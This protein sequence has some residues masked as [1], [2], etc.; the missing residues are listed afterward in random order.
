MDTAK[1][2]T[3]GTFG[4]AK[5]FYSIHACSIVTLV[6]SAANGLAAQLSADQARILELV[7]TSALV[8]SH[9]LP[10]FICRQI[11]HRGTSDLSAIVTLPL[12][13][14][15][16]SSMR[17]PVTTAIGSGDIIEEQLTFYDQKE[18]Y[19]VLSVNGKKANGVEHAQ[20]QGMI[21]AGEFGSALHE[22]FD[23]QSHT[24]FTWDRIARLRARRVY[25]FG[26]HVPPEHGATVMLRYPDRQIT[27]SYG[28]Q[29]FVDVDTLGVLRIKSSLDLPANSPF[30]KGESSVEYEP[31]EIAGKSYNLPSHSEVRLVSKEY[32]YI[33]T[34]D[35]RNYHKFAVES[36]IHYDNTSPK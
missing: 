36:T 18:E 6:F 33:N 2:K 5:S 8:Y 13:S 4:W 25:V 12:G 14:R 35:F 17:L 23:P 22:I 1:G 16:N 27:V 3:T 34:I 9:S 7:R 32:S 20:L 10:N 24:T 15:S 26:F 29:I 30:Q 19:Q 11:T 31:V 28:G 21:S